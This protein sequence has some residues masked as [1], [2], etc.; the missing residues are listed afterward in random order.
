MY[1]VM[2]EEKRYARSQ[3]FSIPDQMWSIQAEEQGMRPADIFCQ[4]PD[5]D[6]PEPMVRRQS[7]EWRTWRGGGG[8]QG[9]SSSVTTFA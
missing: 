4:D 1:V 6:D 3:K 7:R 5:R 8:E 2:T 9:R